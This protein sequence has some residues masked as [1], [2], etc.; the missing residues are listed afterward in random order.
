[1]FQLH[2]LRMLDPYLNRL[3]SEP[4]H[5]GSFSA[6]LD[7]VA[8]WYRDNV[9]KRDGR[10]T[11][12]D[13]STGLRALKLAYVIHAARLCKVDLPSP[14][15]INRLVDLHVARLTDPK[16]LSSGNH[17]LFQMNGLMA[18]VGCSELPGAK[19]ARAFAITQMTK[20][21]TSQLGPE[22]VHTEDAP[23]YHFFARKKI[24]AHCH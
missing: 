19:R 2:A 1:M 4:D 18:L 11:W 15:M 6:I 20:L 12:N 16:E 10:W 5:S 23:Y 3:R 9:L 14:E 21:L 24:A 22:G 17:G 8:D 7:I 13:M